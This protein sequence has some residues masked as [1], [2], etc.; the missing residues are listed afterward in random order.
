MLLKHFP[1]LALVIGKRISNIFPLVVKRF[2]F[3]E[4]P[5]RLSVDF[6]HW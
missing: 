6:C 5:E 3:P 1:D 2:R 4:M